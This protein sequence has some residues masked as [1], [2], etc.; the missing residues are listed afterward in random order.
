MFIL[1]MWILFVFVPYQFF[2]EMS[3][4]NVIVGIDL[5]TI[6]NP[7]RETFRY[8]DLRAIIMGSLF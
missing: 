8:E 2:S 7:F 4:A 3:R 1:G 6:I 5:H